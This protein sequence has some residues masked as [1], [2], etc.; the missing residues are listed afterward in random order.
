MI[1]QSLQPGP[2]AAG[3]PSPDC[4][5]RELCAVGCLALQSLPRS[6]NQA[7]PQVKVQE[8]HFSIS[9]SGQDRSDSERS[10]VDDVECRSRTDRFRGDGGVVDGH[11]RPRQ[12]DLGEIACG[13]QGK[14][15]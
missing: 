3:H 7:A 10:G 5:S 9:L 15:S 11:V 1:G 12:E 13:A 2:Q 6:R 4:L 14:R 8:P